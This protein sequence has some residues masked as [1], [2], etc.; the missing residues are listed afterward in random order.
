MVFYKSSSFSEGV[1]CSG[2]KTSSQEVLRFV[3]Q[4]TE[5]YTSQQAHGIIYDVELMS[6]RRDDVA[7]ISII[8]Q[9]DFIWPLGHM[10]NALH[11]L[12]F[13]FFT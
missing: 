1:C 9:F 12:P 8:F 5:G 2:K 3:Q 10:L 13:H 11:L 4:Q 6:L 7:S